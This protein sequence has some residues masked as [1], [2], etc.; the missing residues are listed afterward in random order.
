MIRPINGGK[1]REFISDRKM[2]ENFH[3]DNR[4]FISI[5][6][7]NKNCKSFKNFVQRFL[8]RV[9]TFQAFK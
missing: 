3:S 2:K 5:H 1:Q 4:K 7:T 8:E 9:N 6:K